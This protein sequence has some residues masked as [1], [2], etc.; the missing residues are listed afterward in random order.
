MQFDMIELDYRAIDVFQSAVAKT[1]DVKGLR[2]IL[3]RTRSESSKFERV[4]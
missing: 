1:A 2:K 4:K 3:C